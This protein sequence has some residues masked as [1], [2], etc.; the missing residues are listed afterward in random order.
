MG[1]KA[2]KIFASW[3]DA[4]IFTL[5]GRRLTSYRDSGGVR[6]T[7]ASSRGTRPT[8]CPHESRIK[9]ESPKSNVNLLTSFLGHRDFYQ[10]LQTIASQLNLLILR[11][12]FYPCSQHITLA[13][14]TC[15]HLTVFLIFFSSFIRTCNVHLC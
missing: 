5:D 15:V 7:V 4:N 11:S 13:Y 6:R 1:Y 14:S 9:V 8:H 2:V 12:L 10:S 3:K